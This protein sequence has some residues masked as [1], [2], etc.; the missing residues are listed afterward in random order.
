MI[1][2][3]FEAVDLN[4]VA[5][6]VTLMVEKTELIFIIDKKGFKNGYYDQK[7]QQR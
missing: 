5:V 4:L 7:F 6:N 1:F 2:D 3:F